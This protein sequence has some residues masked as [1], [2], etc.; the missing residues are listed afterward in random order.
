M[1]LLLIRHINEKTMNNFRQEPYL[2]I[3]DIVIVCKIGWSYIQL[4]LGELCKQV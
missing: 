3:T 2:Q 1:Y 4:I